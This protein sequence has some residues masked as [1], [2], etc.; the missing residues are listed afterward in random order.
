MPPTDQSA[1]RTLTEARGN[2]AGS[3]ASIANLMTPELSKSMSA[4][5]DSLLA[6][7]VLTKYFEQNHQFTSSFDAIV[8]SA[9]AI[10]PPPSFSVA[11]LSPAIS[12]PLSQFKFTAPAVVADISAQLTQSLAAL[13]PVTMPPAVSESLNSLARSAVTPAFTQFMNQQRMFQSPGMTSLSDVMLKLAQPQWDFTSILG[14]LDLPKPLYPGLEFARQFEALQRD[15]LSGLFADI[16][17]AAKLIDVPP[18]LHDHVDLDWDLIE[19]IL[20]DEGI[21]LAWVPPSD[22]VGQLLQ[23]SSPAERRTI[24]GRRWRG[25]TNSCI[26]SIDEVA[27]EGGPIRGFQ[28]FVRDAAL[29]LQDGH[30]V[31]SQTLSANL[32]DTMCRHAFDSKSRTTIT[33]TRR[34]LAIDEYDTHL[35]L[36]YGALRGSF[37]K[38]RTEDGDQVPRSFSRHATAHAVTA[39][40]MSRVNAVIALMQVT[41]LLRLMA[42]A[43]E[44]GALSATVITAAA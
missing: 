40:Q 15:S 12:V 1:W 34:A 23:A 14:K 26:A 17:R 4:F 21:P 13:R 28:R 37:R 10:A 33:G 30:S 41:S 44:R 25:I 24:I 31:P 35:A 2:T 36:V 39:R 22:V 8:R 19:T 38:F 43:P 7:G 9:V 3:A 29:A 42:T 6:S 20:L 16:A 5:G 18:N 27:A 32:L 11:A